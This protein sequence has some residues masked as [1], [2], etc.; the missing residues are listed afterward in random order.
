MRRFELKVRQM[1]PWQYAVTAVLLGLYMGAWWGVVAAITRLKDEPFWSFVITAGLSFGV[2]M[3][4]ADATFKD[5]VLSTWLVGAWFVLPFCCLVVFA[6]VR[7]ARVRK[8]DP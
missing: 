5:P 1:S 3:M 7:T 8:T 6:L 4:M 2:P